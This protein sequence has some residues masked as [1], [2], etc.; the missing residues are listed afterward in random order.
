MY[1]IDVNILGSQNVHI[2]CLLSVL[3]GLKMTV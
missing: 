2:I 3:E 1:F